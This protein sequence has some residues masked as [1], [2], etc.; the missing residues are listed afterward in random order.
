M[1]RTAA[2]CIEWT[3]SRFKN[4]YGQAT[5]AFGTRLAHRVVYMSVYGQ[6]SRETVIMHTCDNKAC[7]NILH[8][9]AGTQS[10]NIRDCISKKRDRLCGERN[11]QAK[12]KNGCI[13]AIR[14]LR[15]TGKYYHRELSELFGLS[16]HHVTNILNGVRG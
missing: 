16:R 11:S 1:N 3:G 4:G 9:V 2:A 10:E 5:R 12:V 13:S 8:L 15:R 6:V 7:V 14:C